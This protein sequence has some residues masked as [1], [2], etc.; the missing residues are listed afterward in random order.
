MTSITSLPPPLSLESGFLENPTQ[1]LEPAVSNYELSF[2]PD[3]TVTTIQPCFFTQIPLSTD[4]STI[5][6]Q[7]FSSPLKASH[8]PTPPP[9]NLQVTVDDYS[10][11]KI[12]NTIN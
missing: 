3:K 8:S 2:T 9:T 10:I 5:H 11:P 6:S 4:V 7:H 12:K 1:T